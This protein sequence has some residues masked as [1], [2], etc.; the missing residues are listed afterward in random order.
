MA[1]PTSIGP[2]APSIAQMRRLGIALL[3]T[4]LLL[5]A[6]APAHAEIEDYASYDPSAKCH[7]KPFAGTQQLGRWVA[8]KHGGGY[9]GT[10]RP[11]RRKDGPTSDHQTGRAF[12]WSVD[13]TKARDRARVKTFLRRIFAEDRAGNT[14][15]LARRMGIAYVIWN[16]RMYPAWTRFRA[17]PYLSSSCP[18]KRTCSQTLRHR[19]H[20]HVSLSKAGARARTVAR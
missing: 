17:E 9:I 19:D 7:P 4:A 16:D 14:D 13:A 5:L 20:V 6:P 11:C 8:R 18:R 1:W 3:A 2:I 10:G 12:D 15:A